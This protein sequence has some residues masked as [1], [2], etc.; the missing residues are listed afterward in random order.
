MF[1]TTI[2]PHALRPITLALTVIYDGFWHLLCGALVKG[3]CSQIATKNSFPVD[4]SENPYFI[5]ILLLIFDIEIVQK[6]QNM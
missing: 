6:L 2:N 1:P 5:N 4:A 3:T